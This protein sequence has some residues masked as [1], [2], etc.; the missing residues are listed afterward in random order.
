MIQSEI[1][2]GARQAMLDEAAQIV[3][4]DAVYLPM[5]VQPLLWGTGDNV[6]LTQR[7]DDF[8]ILRWIT[9]N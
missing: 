7:P 5:Y 6:S 2:D 3:Q 9:V 4:D 8:V 1:D